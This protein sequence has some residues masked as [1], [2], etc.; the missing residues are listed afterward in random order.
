MIP[1][2]LEANLDW[3]GTAP[4]AEDHA[5]IYRTPSM[6]E[7]SLARFAI[8]KG[9]GRYTWYEVCQQELTRGD[10]DGIQT[11][12]PGTNRAHR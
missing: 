8:N 1:Q 11:G 10:I 12:I 5:M 7:C 3:L 4:L 2:P 9:G 6:Q